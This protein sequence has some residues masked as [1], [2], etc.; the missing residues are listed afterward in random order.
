MMAD[1]QVGQSQSTGQFF[2]KLPGNRIQEI[3][4]EQA[5]QIQSDPG[6]ISNILGSAANAGKELLLGGASLFLPGAEDRQMAQQQLTPVQQEQAARSMVS[7]VSTMAGAAIPYI[8]AD[9]AA[10]AAGGLPLAG[11]VGA[12]MGA[13]GSPSDPFF[14]AAAGAAAPVAMGAL[15]TI[16]RG[17]QAAVRGA[18]DGVSGVLDRV[19]G[20][21]AMSGQPRMA[22]RVVAGIDAASPQPQPGRVW[23]GLMQADELDAAGVPLTQSQRLSLGATNEAEMGAARRMKWAEDLRGT[24]PA[25][26]VAQRQAFT[27]MVKSEL[28]VTGPEALTDTVLGNSLRDAGREIG[29]ITSAKGPI[30]LGADAM[31]RMKAVVA[32]ADTTHATALNN[33][34]SDIEA[35]MKRNGGLVDPSDYQKALTRL[36]EMSKPGN[37]FG[38]LQDAG[39]VLDELHEAL[40]K[41]LNPELQAKLAEARYRYKIAK[42]LSE[43]GARGTDFNVNPVQ[44]GSRWD[45]RIS[46][47]ARGRDKL[48]QA[49]DTFGAIGRIEANAGTTLQRLWTQA[50]G[51]IASAAPGAA[52][53]ALGVGGVSNLLGGN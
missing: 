12:G 24:D 25:I 29:G 45:R 35:S 22:D 3:T 21:G 11:I 39:K 31:G 13:A 14:G 41:G 49:A 23:S 15:P 9:A 1:I 44:F 2:A 40:K 7:P 6:M 50:P 5:A 30:D 37:S 16:M 34:V 52:G 38:K 26:Q 51:R 42:T 10:L 17:G 20:L 32:D 8:A 19:P 46:Q 27:N 33:I 18:S 47:S 48:G 53:A 43:S 28:G 4:A 36:N